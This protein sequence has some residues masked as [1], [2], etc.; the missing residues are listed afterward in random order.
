MSAG[1]LPAAPGRR[2]FLRSG[3]VAAAVAAAMG[4]PVRVLAQVLPGTVPA[5]PGALAAPVDAGWHV[6][7]MWGPRYAHPVPYQ[8][9]AAAPELPG[10]APVDRHWVS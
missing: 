3:A 2:A 1:L 6:D 10:V 7:D 9:L 8:H 5:L 4:S